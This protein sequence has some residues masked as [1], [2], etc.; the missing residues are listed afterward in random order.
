V[1]GTFE[2]ER[3]RTADGGATWETRAIT[4]GSP[5]H[6]VRPVAVRG[7]AGG[8]GPAVLWMRTTGGYRHYTDFRCEI[9]GWRAGTPVEP[10]AGH[11]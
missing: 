2:I 11:H 7:H 8:T 9:W 1:N 4:A 5:A 3:R 6:N 10:T